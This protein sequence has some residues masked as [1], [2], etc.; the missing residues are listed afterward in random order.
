VGELFS[1]YL[2]PDHEILA[3]GDYDCIGF[4]DSFGRRHWAPRQDILTTLPHIREAC[5]KSGKDW[6]AKN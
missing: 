6:R 1:V 5:A 2:I 3:R 4:N